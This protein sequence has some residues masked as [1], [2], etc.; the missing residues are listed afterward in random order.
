MTQDIFKI[1]THNGL[2][3][4]DD[5]FACQILYGINDNAVI[6][7]TRDPKELEAC[8]V[9]VDIGGIYDS[10]KGKFDHHQKNGPT[11]EDGIP[12][13]ACGL[14][15]K[16][17]GR[18]Y[19]LHQYADLSS[20]L[21]DRIFEKIDGDI[22][23]FI[24]KV[25]NQIIRPEITSIGEYII[26][27]NNGGTLKAFDKAMDIARGYLAVSIEKAR[28]YAINEN[29]LIALAK[30]SRSNKLNYIIADREVDV[31]CL[32]EKEGI[33]YAI[34]PSYDGRT[35]MIKCL[36]YDNNPVEIRHPFRQEYRGLR[37]E[38]LKTTGIDGITFVHH[39]GF[40]GGAKTI[41]D[42]IKMI[43]LTQ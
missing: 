24:D 28:E 36:P 5:V 21:V 35:V 9:L 4:P 23:L 1:G 11:R 43:S 22:I 17:Y 2:H 13:S 29:Y 6:I 40:C 19:I 31:N 25:D 37:S 3:H 16:H 32:K 20:D 26:M 27:T 12:Y 15:W 8:D 30:E 7:R 18:D 14:V 39:R 41:D 34:Y 38:D 10:E 33:D 42:A